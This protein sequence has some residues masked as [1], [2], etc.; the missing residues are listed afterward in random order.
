MKKNENF[1]WMKI[2]MFRIEMCLSSFEKAYP[3]T[4]QKGFLSVLSTST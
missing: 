3:K 4:L 2:E 1:N